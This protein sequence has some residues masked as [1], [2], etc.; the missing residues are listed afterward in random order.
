MTNQITIAIIFIIIAQIEK[1]FSPRLE[2]L[3][4]D[5]LLILFYSAKN[6]RKRLIFKI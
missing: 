1:I 4:E 5:S 3:E 2:Y 6:T